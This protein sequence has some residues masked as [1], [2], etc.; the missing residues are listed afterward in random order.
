MAGCVRRPLF[1]VRRRPVDARPPRDR[2]R[3]WAVRAAAD[4]RAAGGEEADEQQH[5]EAHVC[6]Y[7]LSPGNTDSTPHVTCACGQ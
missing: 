4:G 7:Y 2:R 3:C 5:E 6:D 1:G